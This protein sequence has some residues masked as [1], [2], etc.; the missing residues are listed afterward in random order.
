MGSNTWVSDSALQPPTEIS[1]CFFW[2]CW[3]KSVQTY[4]R[5]FSIKSVLLIMISTSIVYSV[6]CLLDDTQEPTSHPQFLFLPNLPHLAHYQVL[7]AN[8]F[9]I[10]RIHQLFPTTTRLRLLY[11]LI[12]TYCSLLSPLLIWQTP[13]NLPVSVFKSHFLSEAFQNHPHTYP[14]PLHM[15]HPGNSWF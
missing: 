10:S 7:P 8:P 15:H 2:K 9:N 5:F 13:L 3:T 4:L 1:T 6:I 11:T 12:C 14:S